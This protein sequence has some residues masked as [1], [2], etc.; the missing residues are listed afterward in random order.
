MQKGKTNNK[1]KTMKKYLLTSLIWLISNNTFAQI[2][3]IVGKWSE[4]RCIRTDTTDTGYEILNKD[5]QAYIKGYKKLDPMYTDQSVI[6]PEEGDKLKVTIIK[7]EDFFW[8]T[9][10][11][12]LKEKIKYTPG[13]KE[14]LIT[15]KKYWFSYS[16]IVKYDT[17]TDKLLFLNHRSQDICHEFERIK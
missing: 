11:N 1:I 4:T 15:I 16:Y 7:E 9:D 10:G 12:K 3:K 13:F 6:V 14:Y 17:K 2:D 8:A 5:W